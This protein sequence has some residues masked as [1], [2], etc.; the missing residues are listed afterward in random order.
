[1][2]PEEN[3]K[4]NNINL[5]KAS[6]PVGS[7]LSCKK[8]SNFLFIS[9]QISIDEK[10]TLIK[11]KLGK[12]LTTEEGYEAAKRC[13]LSLIA[14]AKKFCDGDLNKVKKC[15]KIIGYINSNEEFEKHP[16]VLN[17][18]S[19]LLVNIFGEKGKHTRA[20]IGVKSLPLGAMIEIESLFE[21]NTN[22]LRKYIS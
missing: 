6:D 20:V 22:S 1:M 2:S 5:P 12:D 10:N 8:S 16:M 18:A 21:I 4:K 7:Y 13:A 15:I 9:G 14:Q 19:D 3:L 17:T 11:G